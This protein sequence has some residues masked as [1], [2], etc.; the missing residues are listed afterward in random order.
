MGLTIKA[1]RARRGELKEEE[2]GYSS[3]HKFFGFFA[4]FESQERVVIFIDL[5]SGREHLRPDLISKETFTELAT[6]VDPTI[7]VQHLVQTGWVSY[8]DAGIALFLKPDQGRE[9][10]IESLLPVIQAAFEAK[11]AVL[12]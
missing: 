3:L 7:T 4:V 12:V 11:H 6:K 10:G 8:D 2:L 5:L 9:D 1:F